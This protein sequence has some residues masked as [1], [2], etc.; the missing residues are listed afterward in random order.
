MVVQVTR[1][2]IMEIPSP[3]GTPLGFLLKILH[4]SRGN[5]ND[6]TKATVCLP[7]IPTFRVVLTLNYFFPCHQLDYASYQMKGTLD[8]AL[9][10]GQN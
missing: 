5:T 2:Q 3:E 8:F 1:Q 9:L 4:E 7:A 6:L 10:A